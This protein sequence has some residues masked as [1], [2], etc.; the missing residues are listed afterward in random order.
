M[1][2]EA[3]LSAGMRPVISRHPADKGTL[4]AEF[5]TDESF[6]DCLEDCHVS[7]QRFASGILEALARQV[8]VIYFNP[9][10]EKVD[11]FQTD[12]MHAYSLAAEQHELINALK[13][14]WKLHVMA[15]DNGPRF[16][17]DHAG[18]S[19]A[20]MIEH[21]CKEIVASVGPKGTSA[22]MEAFREYIAAIDVKTKAM[23]E[24]VTRD[25]P[26][27]PDI[28]TAEDSIEALR[29]DYLRNHPN[30]QGPARDIPQKNDLPM[31]FEQL[32]ENHAITGEY[33]NLSPALT[34]ARGDNC[35]LDQLTRGNDPATRRLL[36]S[37]CASAL[38]LSPTVTTRRLQG[39]TTLALAVERALGQLPTSD[40]LATHFLRVEKHAKLVTEL[41][42]D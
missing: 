22:R 42:H 8:G 17:E 23:T 4:F 25:G 14:W 1:S 34:D 30:L 15:R 7:I 12:P 31:A 41:E 39:E 27:F 9:H 10:G 18:I 33:A 28:H 38:L 26:L 11:K 36:L 3:V 40:P 37:S 16:L 13:D 6:Y 20:D 2:V 21:A 32:P 24:C 29:I 5:V 19:S 35:L